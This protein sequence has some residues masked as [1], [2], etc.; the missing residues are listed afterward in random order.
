MKKIIAVLMI[1]LLAISLTACAGQP[2]NQT[3]TAAETT[4]AAP[5]AETT[6]TEVATTEATTEEATTTEGAGSG[7][8]EVVDSAGNTITFEKSPQRTIC[9]FGSYADLWVEAG[10]DLVGVVD[11]KILNEKIADKPKVGKISTPNIEAILALEP[12]FIIIRADYEKQMDIMPVMEENGIPVYQCNYNSLEETAENYMNFCKILGNENL[13][14]EKMEP[15]LEQVK[16]LQEN[17]KDFTYLLL[18]STSKSVST[19][20]NNVSAEIIDGLGGN[21]ITKDYQIADEETK[22]F[23]FEKILE[24]DP[25]YIFVQTMGSVEKAKERLE[26]DIYSNPAWASL[27]AVQNG[28]FYYLPK[29]LFLYKPNMKY[30]EAY[31]YMTDILE[32]K[33]ESDQ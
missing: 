25:D 12:D 4:T 31:Q 16:T 22:Q 20:D 11:T 29:D 8:I 32:G 1:A 30:P 33:I 2:D 26:S 28:K 6:T 24:A 15:M 10:G 13:Y 21:N 3:T 23:S 18:F 5:A 27:T 9:L 19:K 7:L 14:A 17:K